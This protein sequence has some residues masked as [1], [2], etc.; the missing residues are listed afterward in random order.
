MPQT[1]LPARIG[2]D[3]PLPFRVQAEFLAELSASDRSAG[4]CSASLEMSP[5]HSVQLRFGV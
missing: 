4:D 5:L 2:P 1:G 3:R